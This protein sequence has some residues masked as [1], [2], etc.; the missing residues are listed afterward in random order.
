VDSLLIDG[1]SLQY[2]A[3][4]L[5][6]LDNVLFHQIA[7]KNIDY[8]DEQFSANGIDLQIQS[9]QWNGQL[10]PYGEVQLAADQ[11]YWNGEAFN[12]VLVDIDYK[13]QD[14]TLYGISFSWRNSQISGQGEQYPQGWSLVNV[15]INKLKLSNTQR[16]SLLAKPWHDLPFNINHINSLDLLNADIEWGDWHWQNLDLSVE[17]ATLPL[18]LWR[19]KAQV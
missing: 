6:P 13:P 19:T 8:A 7:L 12:Q 16:Q 17:N 15:T 10:I 11:L 2:G 1:M 4:K 18:S 14:S 5:P 3:P 9:P